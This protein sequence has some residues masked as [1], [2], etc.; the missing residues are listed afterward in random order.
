MTDDHS[1]SQ[2]HYAGCWKSRGHHECAITEIEALR[3]DI[4][5]HLD[6]CTKQAIEIE[7]LREAL[8]R[9]AD[10]F[11]DFGTFMRMTDR[12]V[13]VGICEIAEGD[14]RAALSDWANQNR[15]CAQPREEWDP[16]IHGT[17]PISDN[18]R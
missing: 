18:L 15:D 16:K 4:D 10:T 1:R 5:R 9:S 11:K 2:T 3:H 14:A 12:P 13:L 7:R 6:I 8:E 17:G